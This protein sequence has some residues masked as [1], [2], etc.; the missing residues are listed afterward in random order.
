MSIPIPITLFI[1]LFILFITIICLAFP[2]AL[3]PG[4]NI[5]SYKV[6]VKSGTITSSLLPDSPR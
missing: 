6:N 2:K 1:Y 4:I 5:T 3:P